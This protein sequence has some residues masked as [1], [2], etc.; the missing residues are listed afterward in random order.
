M[1]SRTT[2]LVINKT[3]FLTRNAT[4]QKGWKELL[5]HVLFLLSFA[6]LQLL[7]CFTGCDVSFCILLAK[8]FPK[9]ACPEC[10]L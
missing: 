1:S 9:G 6:S 2:P 3:S 4:F 8:L 7:V 10:V 5:T